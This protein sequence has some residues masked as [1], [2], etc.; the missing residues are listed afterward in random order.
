MIVADTDVLIDALR[1]REPGRTQVAHA[2]DAGSLATTTVSMFELL[3]G[4]GAEAERSVVERLLGPLPILPLDERAARAAATVRRDL[5]SQGLAIGM[6]DLLIAGI[7]LAR[8]TSLLTRNRTHFERVR[9]LTLVP[10]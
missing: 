8:S 9:G 6:A 10:T 4:A 7:C 5:A 1:G 2:L 3:S